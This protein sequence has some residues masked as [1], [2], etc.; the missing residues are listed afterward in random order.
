MKISTLIIFGLFII[1]SAQGES[2]KASDNEVKLT[3]TLLKK[4]FTQSKKES[5]NIKRSEFDITP[6]NS[7]V[8]ESV[9]KFLLKTPKD[10]IITSIKFKI[11]NAFDLFSKEKDY[12]P[13]NLIEGPKGKE[14]HI[15][16]KDAKTGFYRLYVKVKTKKDKNIYHHFHSSYVDH[17]KFVYEKNLT[18]VPQPDPAINNSTILGID[19]DNDGIRDDVQN[20]INKNASS[21]TIRL[22]LRQ[23]ATGIRNKYANK[24]NKEESILATHESLKAQ[25]CLRYKQREAQEKNT[26]SL[27]LEAFHRNTKARIIASDQISSNF[28]GQLMERVDKEIACNF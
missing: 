20:W 6:L 1:G 15:P 12:S 5:G 8:K 28:H 14:L 4:K 25:D 2:K 7:P 11:K 21:E 27:E 18:E 9:A 17:V 16:M 23:Y 26:L 10:F 19:S 13:T 22:A 3:K 24:D